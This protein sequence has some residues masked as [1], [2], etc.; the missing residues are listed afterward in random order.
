MVRWAIIEFSDYLNFYSAEACNRSVIKF[1]DDEW[2][3]FNF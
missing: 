2:I 3:I 1:I